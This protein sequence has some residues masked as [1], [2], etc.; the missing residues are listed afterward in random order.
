MITNLCAQKNIYN[1]KNQTKSKLEEKRTG[2]T[3]NLYFVAEKCMNYLQQ[4]KFEVLN[5]EPFF[6]FLSSNQQ[7]LKYSV[8]I[9]EHFGSLSK[10]TEYVTT[11]KVLTE[12]MDLIR[13]CRPNVDFTCHLS[14]LASRV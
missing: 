10:K 3:T 12:Q 4:A 14:A 2:A 7:I 11:T 8:T 5:N 1:G 13:S 6:F 9:I